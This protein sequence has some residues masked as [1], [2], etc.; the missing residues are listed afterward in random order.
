M[1]I[2]VKNIAFIYVLI[3]SAATC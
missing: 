2:N 1:D 3:V